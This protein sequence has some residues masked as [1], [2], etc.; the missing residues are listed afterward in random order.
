MP[1]SS[2]S[3]KQREALFGV[4]K[5]SARSRESP[6]RTKDQDGVISIPPPTLAHPHGGLMQRSQAAT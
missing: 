4:R 3:S 6:C 2:V 5:G 1:S